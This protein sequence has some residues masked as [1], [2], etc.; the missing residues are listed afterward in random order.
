LPE[1]RISG[2]TEAIAG[3]ERHAACTSIQGGLTM[4]HPLIVVGVDGSEQSK[5]ALRWALD[6]ARLRGASLRVVH[7][8][9]AYPAFVPGAP[10]IATEW[11]ELRESADEFVES[12][13]AEVLGEPDDVEITAVAVHGTA[14][15]ALVEASQEADLLVVGSRGLGGFTGLLLGSVSQ[16]CAHHAPCP[17]VIVRGAPTEQNPEAADQSRAAAKA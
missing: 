16:Q 1:R 2:R 9:W 15:P 8:W 5:A 13:V 3:H 7:A 6:E 10:I 17:L 11:E 14:A 4:E 12:F